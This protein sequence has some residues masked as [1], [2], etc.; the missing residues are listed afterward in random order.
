MLKKILIIFFSCLLGI[1]SFEFLYKNLNLDKVSGQYRDLLRI[2]S[3]WTDQ[4][5]SGGRVNLENKIWTYDKNNEFHHRLFVKTDDGWLEEFQYKHNS[6]N[7]GLNQET[8]IFK[9]KKSIIFFG[10]SVP[11]GWGANP[12]FNDL[13]KEFTTDYQ[14]INGSL[15]GTGVFSW[16]IFH[17]HLKKQD[18]KIEKILMFLHGDFWVN[19][20]KVIPQNQI[21]CL[22][23]YKFCDNP[24]FLQFGMP[25]NGDIKEIEMYLDEL[26]KQRSAP[27]IKKA[28][29]VGSLKDFL[30]YL[31]EM[32]PATYQIYRYSR[33]KYNK[34]LNEK[35]I[36]KFINE[37]QNNL[38]IVHLPQEIEYTEGKLT[39]DS[40]SL[41][42]FIKKNNGIIFNS[43]EKCE[44]YSSQDYF[45]YEGHPNLIGYKKLKECSKKALKELILK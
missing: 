44:K 3:L 31:R 13:Q 19:V 28:S 15:H 43:F 5:Q 21:D 36:K 45:Y 26:H 33:I 4:N 9:N 32:L 27:I 40:K 24:S 35:E 38:M 22:R 29:Y 18:I 16:R 30:F 39:N 20:A 11:E 10:A 34:Y 17:D 37:Y 2:Y 7:F 6:N 8:D 42:K 41:I 1:F 25:P 23:N 14:L 12:W